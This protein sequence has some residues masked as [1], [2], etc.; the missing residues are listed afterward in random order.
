MNLFYFYFVLINSWVDNDNLYHNVVDH[1]VTWDQ[2][3]NGGVHLQIYD[4][5]TGHVHPWW[6][7]QYR[8]SDLPGRRQCRNLWLRNFH[9]GALFDFRLF[10][11]QHIAVMQRPVTIWHVNKYLPKFDLGQFFGGWY[12]LGEIRRLESGWHQTG[13][14]RGS[15]GTRYLQWFTSLR[16]AFGLDH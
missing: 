5:R 6:N 11:Y 7:R 12:T 16:Y 2:S 3:K 15:G 13:L 4:T 10:I 14:V 8:P 9:R 1:P